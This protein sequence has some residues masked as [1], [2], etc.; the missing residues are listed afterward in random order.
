MTDY[1][2]LRFIATHLLADLHLVR[3]VFHPEVR[4]A[5]NPLT[6][7]GIKMKIMQILSLLVVILV[8]LS[9]DHMMIW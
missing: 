7:L 5:A 8:L 1:V 3:W 6:N 2:S 4:V 9:D